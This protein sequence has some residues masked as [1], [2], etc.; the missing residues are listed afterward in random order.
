MNEFVN[1]LREAF[2]PLKDHPVLVARIAVVLIAL[3][4]VYAAKS[5]RKRICLS[6]HS[7]LTE[8]IKCTTRLLC[9]FV[10][11]DDITDRTF[12]TSEV[13]GTGKDGDDMVWT[14]VHWPSLRPTRDFFRVH[15]AL[16]SLSAWEETKG[17]L[18]RRWKIVHSP[19]SF[20]G[21]L[22]AHGL[23]SLIRRATAK[24]LWALASI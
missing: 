6:L 1:F 14:L 4:V 20:I 3:G 17:I 10:N 2:P 11:P 5:L 23:R 8:R 24:V 19:D 22:P 13:L 9:V 21:P 16:G 7:R 12:Y 15:A 18:N